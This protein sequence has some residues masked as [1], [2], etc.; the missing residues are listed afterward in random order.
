[1]FMKDEIKG[2]V[3]VGFIIVIVVLLFNYLNTKVNLSDKRVLNYL[4]N[5]FDYVNI[6]DKSNKLLD[7]FN[8]LEIIN[9]SNN[10]I[11]FLD[12]DKLLKEYD[13]PK[14]ETFLVFLIKK[15]LSYISITLIIKNSIIMIRMHHIT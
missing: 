15:I 8:V 3:Y 10:N 13:T 4:N 5:S 11:T 12:S 14:T 7:K 2:V 6:N 1:M 9:A